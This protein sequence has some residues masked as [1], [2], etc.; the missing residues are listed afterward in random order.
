MKQFTFESKEKKINLQQNVQFTNI[1]NKIGF[2]NDIILAFI[3]SS[4]ELLNTEDEKCPTNWLG[5]YP[6][7]TTISLLLWFCFVL[8]NCALV[9]RPQ[10]STIRCELYDSTWPFQYLQYYCLMRYETVIGWRICSLFRNH[11]ITVP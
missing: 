5:T 11:K 8:L 1:F 3:L 10:F 2:R 7:N 4:V 9:G 6:H